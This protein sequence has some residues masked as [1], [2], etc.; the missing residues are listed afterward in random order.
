MGEMGIFRILFGR[1]KTEPV[2]SIPTVKFDKSRVTARV[3]ADLRRSIS[4]IAD[5]KK[6]DRDEVYAAAVKSI[7]AGRDLGSLARGLRDICGLSQRRAA[8]IAH[9]LNGEATATMNADQQTGLGI[10]HA[11]WVYSGA[12][13]VPH[14]KSATDDQWKVDAA[15]KAADGKTYEVSKGMK[16]AGVWVR[17]GQLEFCKCVSRSIIKALEK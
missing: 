16:L 17:P 10:T 1:S 6:S 12:P 7:E 2:R 15:H 13:C 4:Q 11:R 9:R 8:E 3:R 5:I 14:P